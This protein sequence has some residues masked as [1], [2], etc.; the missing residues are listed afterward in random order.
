MIRVSTPLLL[1]R[2]AA[3]SPEDG[4]LQGVVPQEPLAPEVQTAS[5]APDRREVLSPQ[6]GRIALEALE[7]S[8]NNLVGAHS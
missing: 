2:S 5:G 4:R 3:T 6:L 7:P 1:Q 8:T